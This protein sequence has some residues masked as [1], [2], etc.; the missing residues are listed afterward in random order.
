LGYRV[1]RFT[2][3]DVLGNSDGVFDVL[4]SMLGEP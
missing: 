2:N 3:S 4:R 1:M